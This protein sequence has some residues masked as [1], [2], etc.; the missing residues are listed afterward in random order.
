MNAHFSFDGNAVAYLLHGQEFTLDI[1]AEACWFV[2]IKYHSG[3]GIGWTLHRP[4]TRFIS[5][6]NAHRPTISVWGLGWG[7][8]LLL[9]K[10]LNINCLN[11]IRQQVDI[12]RS[13]PKIRINKP[14]TARLS[15]IFKALLLIKMPST[16]FNTPSAIHTKTNPSITINTDQL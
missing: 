6:A 3:L 2:L 1:Q 16:R 4:H 14:I 12:K 5:V 9:H 13:R 15:Q 10:K 11:V 8:K 7:V